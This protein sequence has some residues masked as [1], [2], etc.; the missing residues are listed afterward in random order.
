MLYLLKYLS[1]V[2]GDSIVEDGIESDVSERD[3][4][5]KG[6]RL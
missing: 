4:Y 1:W 6:S 5:R 2:D 3:V